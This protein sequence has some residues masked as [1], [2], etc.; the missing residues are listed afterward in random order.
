MNGD[1]LCFEPLA[2][3]A[4]RIRRR[5]LSST[6]V[7]RAVLDRIGVLAG[8]LNCYITVTAESALAQ[9]EALDR[10]QAAGTY[11]GPLHGV[12]VALKDNISTAGVRTTMGSSIFADN[13]PTADATVAARL[14][15]AGAVL[16]GKNNLY[17]FAFGA[18]H[19][20]YGAVRNPWD[21]DRSCAG[22]SNGSGCA[23]AAG[24]TYAAL[25][26]DTGGSVRLPAAYCGVVG[27]KPTYG[28]VSRAGVVPVSYNLD[29]VGPLT[30]TVGDAAL[31]LAAIAGRD[32]AD[33]TTASAAV[34]DYMPS[35]EKGV[36]GLQLGIA[37]PQPG[38]EADPEVA[39][40][41]AEAYRVLEASGAQ[42][43]EVDLPSYAYART[44][45]WAVGAVEGA[46]WHRGLLRSRADEYHPVVRTSFEVGEFVPAVEYV[47]MQRVRQ[48]MIDQMN[49]I[50]REVDAVL[51]PTTVSVAHPIGAQ[52]IM[53]A[54]REQQMLSALTQYTPLANVTGQPALAVPCGFSDTGLP[55]SFQVLGRRFDENMVFRVARAYERESNWIRRRPPG[56]PTTESATPSPF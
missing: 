41:V 40:A 56:S 24:L 5:E 26:T 29:H 55:I 38:E 31:V 18:P 9:A 48:V 42:L 49:Q 13:V 50:M 25:G 21:L 10:L 45:M 53:V 30:R 32:P 43:I 14:R 1:D 51:M 37:R 39:T 47:H 36:R 4:E 3:I 15:L 28:R 16:I 19:P 20:M 54:G 34:P 27:L 44:I 2:S 35:L 23:V 52:T 33:P 22:S 12:P 11:L 8:Q 46:E 17:E 6:T 7:T